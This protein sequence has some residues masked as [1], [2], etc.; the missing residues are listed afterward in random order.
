MVLAA[1]GGEAIARLIFALRH[2][3][4]VAFIAI[5]VLLLHPLV[6]EL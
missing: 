1:I 3:G 2:F 4:E 6:V 5:A